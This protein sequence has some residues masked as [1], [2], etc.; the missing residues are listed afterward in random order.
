EQIAAASEE[1]A[2]AA[3]ESLSAINEIT[4][5]TE[6]IQRDAEFGINKAL[7]MVEVAKNTQRD[8]IHA[9]ERMLETVEMSRQLRDQAS[10]LEKASSDIG[11]S[12]TLIA[13]VAEET[14]LLALNAA[15]EAARAKEHGKGFAVVAGETRTL[16]AQAA[17]S[18]QATGEVVSDVQQKVGGLVECIAR[19]SEQVAQDAP[20]AQAAAQQ[21]E[22]VGDLGSQVAENMQ[23]LGKVMDQMIN[24]ISELQKGAEVIASAAEEQASAVNQASKSID[25]QATALVESEQAATNLEV[26]AEELKNSTDTV[27]D[28]EEIAAMAEQLS[29]AIEAIT[30]GMGEVI[31]ALEQIEKAAALANEDAMKNSEVADQC[32]D[33]VSRAGSLLQTAFEALGEISQISEEMVEH[34]RQISQAVEGSVAQGEQVTNQIDAVNKDLR[35]ITKILRTI[36]NIIIQTTMLAVSGSV[37]AARAG[38]FGKGFAVVSSDIRNLAQEASTNIEKIDEIITSLEEEMTRISRSWTQGLGQLSV[39][40]DQLQNMVTHLESVAQEIEEVV[41]IVEGLKRAN[42]E[43]AAALNQAR[44]GSEQIKLAAVQAQT[45]VAESR[46]AAQLIH[47][48][49]EEMREQVEELAVLADQLQM[50]A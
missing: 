14:N 46:S 32:I 28:A 31:S 21:A 22:Q 44:Q 33:F 49:L 42:E 5:N 3:E 6:A 35:R 18:A 48:T 9:A 13:Q 23:Q 39:N 27:K 1:N 47:D 17:E 11:E 8:V 2:G 12:V 16:A 19:V 38:E 7:S 26:L 41:S 43:N 36:E 50:T 29:S 30:Q 10:A 25:M 40:A 20:K 34:L 24:E 37:E 15:I 45:N 4:K